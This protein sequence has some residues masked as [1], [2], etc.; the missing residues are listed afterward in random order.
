M[1]WLGLGGMCAPTVISS[2]PL[3]V[4]NL[5]QIRVLNLQGNQ[6]D[7]VEAKAESNDNDHYSHY[8]RGLEDLTTLH[9]PRPSHYDTLA[10]NEV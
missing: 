5:E 10:P 4:G 9:A 6:F 8:S 3:S 1:R 2:I 7:V